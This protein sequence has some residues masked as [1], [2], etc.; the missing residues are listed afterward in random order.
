[1]IKRENF[2]VNFFNK[3]KV[4]FA[5][6]GVSALTACTF[7]FNKPPESTENFI[8]SVTEV[9]ENT[10]WASLT[11]EEATKT[12]EELTEQINNL[13]DLQKVELMR[14]VDGDTLVVS[15]EGEKAKVRLIGIDTPESVASKEYLKKSGKK[16]TKAGKDASEYVKKLLENTEYLYLE[17]D[18]SDTDR[19]GRLLRYVW[20]EVPEDTNNIEEISEKCLNGVLL[21][22]GYAKAVVYKPD[23]AKSE[24]FKE[25]EEDYDER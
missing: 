5:V 12:T 11:T 7:N 20:L 25:I 10:D 8:S 13:A 24:I 19:Y 2:M 3:A 16:N 17:K 4:L 15:I 21:K 22:E 14:V 1:M 6:V 9:V 18:K 23:T